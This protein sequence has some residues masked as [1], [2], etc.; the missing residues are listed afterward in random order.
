MRHFPFILLLLAI[1]ITACSSPDPETTTAQKTIIV[2]VTREVTVR[3]VVEVT[4]EVEVTRLLE[5]TRIIEHPVTVT[6]T[7]TPVNSHP[8][9]PLQPLIWEQRRPLKRKAS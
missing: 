1:L 5:V 6:P 4:R 2:E 9:H 3:A 7:N 8:H